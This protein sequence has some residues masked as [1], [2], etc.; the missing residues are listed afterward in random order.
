M[1]LPG[2]PVSSFVL[3]TFLHITFREFISKKGVERNIFAILPGKIANTAFNSRSIHES[4][5]CDYRW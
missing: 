4:I 1:T 5:F 2:I 3:F